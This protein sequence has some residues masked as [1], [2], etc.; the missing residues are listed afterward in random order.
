ML[1]C[2]AFVLIVKYGASMLICGAFV[3]LIWIDG[4]METELDWGM[5]TGWRTGSCCCRGQWLPVSACENQL[6]LQMFICRQTTCYL[7][8]LV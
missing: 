8:K 3:N 1:I 4:G 7:E 6:F 5:V 2:D